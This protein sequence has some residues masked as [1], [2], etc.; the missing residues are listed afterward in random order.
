M[1]DEDAEFDFGAAI[2]APLA[3]GAA[4]VVAASVLQVSRAKAISA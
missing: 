4:V 1:E 3:A 2:D